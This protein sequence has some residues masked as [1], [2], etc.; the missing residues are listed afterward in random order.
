MSAVPPIATSSQT[1]GPFFHHGLK[2][3][4]V[5]AS[6]FPLQLTLKVTDGNGDPVDDALIELWTAGTFARVATGKDGTCECEVSRTPYINVC[7]FARGLL[8]HLHTRI[9]FDADSALASDPVLALVPDARRHTLIARQDSA[10]PGGW[11][12]HVRLQGAQETVFFDI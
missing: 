2:P 10:S 12:F 1:I 5:G 4:T 11:I 7:L 9:Y 8:R 3:H 6:G